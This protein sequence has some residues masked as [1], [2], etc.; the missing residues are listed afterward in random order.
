MGILEEASVEWVYHY[1]PLHYLPFIARGHALCSKP[2]LAAA[3]FPQ[4]HLR[5]MS[6]AQDVA[7]GFGAYTLLTLAAHP[8]I[9]KAKLGA[10][11]PHVQIMVPARNVDAAEF[12]LC[13]Y[14]VAM[15]RYL[16]RDGKPGSPESPTNGYYYGNHQVPVA[17]ATQDK[18]AMLREHLPRGTM[19]EV[20]VHGSLPLNG[21]VRVVCF[22][23]QDFQT[24]QHILASINCHWQCHLG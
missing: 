10:G 23:N 17:R 18:V 19:I 12:S 22:S 14:N 11:F 20:L 8:N 13:R 21:D 24:A 3:G 2:A 1:T 15:T 16:R 6:K 9:L 4:R 5:S 7:R